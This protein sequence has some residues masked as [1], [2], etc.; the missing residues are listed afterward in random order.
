MG[1][2]HIPTAEL[3]NIKE[4]N[5]TLSKVASVT[6]LESNDQETILEI[7]SGTYSFRVKGVR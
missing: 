2:I 4:G 7:G 1:V 5:K 3:S 6:I